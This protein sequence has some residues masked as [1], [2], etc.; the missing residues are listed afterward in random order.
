MKRQTL[1]HLSAAVLA[2]GLAAVG[3]SSAFAAS[4]CI[5]AEQK[6]PYSIGWANIYS[7]ERRLPLAGAIPASRFGW[8][9]TYGGQEYYGALTFV[10]AL[11]P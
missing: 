4:K 7:A 8:D 6:P 3:T 1:R 11:A 10:L 5:T 9:M 2:F